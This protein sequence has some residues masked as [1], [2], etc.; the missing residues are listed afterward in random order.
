MVVE[1]TARST[2]TAVELD[3]GDELLF[4]LTTGQIRR[5]KILATGAQVYRSNKDQ[6]DRRGPVLVELQ[7]TLTMEID[8]HRVVINRWVGNQKSFYEP[9]KLFGMHLWFDACAKLFDHLAEVHGICKPRKDVRLA[10]QDATL[11]ICPVLLHPWCPLPD[12]TLRIE[13]CYEG[14]DCWMGPYFGTDAHGGLDIN[15]PAGT[16]IWSPISFDDQYYFNSLA[17]GAN[18]NRWRG[19]KHWAD[20]STWHLQVHHLVRLLVP[21]RT[22]VE[23]G[24]HMAD[25]AGVLCGHYEH[26]HFVFA[27]IEPGGAEEDRILLDPWIIFWQTYQDRRITQADADR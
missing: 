23:A 1:K 3:C 17:G 18:N 2:V 22:A 9:W 4:T 20:G 15:H 8:G 27:I 10:V 12:R 16:P 21:E 11:R 26:S 25:G 5:I 6:P 14:S 13:D 19:I 24:V 7:M